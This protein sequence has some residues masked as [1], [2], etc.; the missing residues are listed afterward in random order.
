MKPKTL[1]E[2]ATPE[3]LGRV[4]LNFASHAMGLLTEWIKLARLHDL[5]NLIAFFLGAKF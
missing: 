5:S 3:I 2:R 1:F 4:P